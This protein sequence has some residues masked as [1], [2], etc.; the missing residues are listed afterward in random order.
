MSVDVEVHDGNSSGAGRNSVVPDEIR[1][2][3]WGA[4]GL[5]WL[6]GLGNQT[7][8]ALLCLVPF[9][10][11]VMMFVLGAQ[12][13]EWAWRNRR[14][15]SV[16][17]FQRVQ[18]GWA[19]ATL[20][21]LG[22]TFV[23]VMVAIVLG[24]TLLTSASDEVKALAVARLQSHPAAIAALGEP[25]EVGRIQSVNVQTADSY[26]AARIV[27]PTSGPLATG[28]VTALAQLEDGEWELAWLQ[29]VVSGQELE[30]L[31]P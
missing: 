8:I 18:R 15:N 26:G 1:R 27:F 11:I 19:I 4:F 10:N 17:H 30:L 28:T 6:W 2:W 5:N 14:W 3:N 20:I 7:H 16:A 24:V 9:V 21:L 29:L 12:G 23:G 31:D 13:S 22:T 25:I